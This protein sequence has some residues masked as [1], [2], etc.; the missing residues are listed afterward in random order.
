MPSAVS[1]TK[2]ACRASPRPAPGSPES[3]RTSRVMPGRARTRSRWTSGGAVTTTHLVHPVA[4]AGLE[5]QRNVEHDQRRALRRDGRSR[6][7]SA[8]ARTSGWTIA[9]S[10]FSAAG[11]RARGSAS[12]SRSTAPSVTVPGNAALDQRR[13]RARIEAMHRLV[14]VMDRN[15]GVAEHRA[16]VDLPMPIEP[17]EPED[18]HLA[19]GVVM[20]A[21]IRARS[22]GVTSGRPPNQRSNP[23]T[24]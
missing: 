22:S 21:M 18:D 11:R 4:P 2:S 19:R 24:A 9:S 10:R 7:A 5:Q 8:S 3:P 16:V 15:A 23:G 14:G 1:M 17:G 20:S 6:K 12:R 13:R